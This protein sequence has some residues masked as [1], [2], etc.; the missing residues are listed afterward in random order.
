M[1][2]NEIAEAEKVS[3]QSDAILTVDRAE[4]KA[5]QLMRVEASWNEIER[6]HAPIRKNTLAR[7]EKHGNEVTD[8]IYTALMLGGGVATGITLFTHFGI[9]VAPAIVFGM[10]SGLVGGV[11][12]GGAVDAIAELLFNKNLL[13]FLTTRVF[14]RKKYRE[15]DMAEKSIYEKKMD[16]Y[17]SN[18]KR[19]KKLEKKILKKVDVIIKEYNSRSDDFALSFNLQNGNFSRIEK[20]VEESK[21]PEEYILIGK[22]LAD[23]AIIA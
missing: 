14:L 19:Q 1:M 7:M 10:F 15:I 5:A 16:A 2:E 18:I 6:P 9:A 21:I 22:E 12:V 23:R 13:G 3:D 17:R 8:N 20:P 4:A 11:L